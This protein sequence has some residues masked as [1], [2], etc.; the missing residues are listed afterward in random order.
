[1]YGLIIYFFLP[2]FS[3]DYIANVQYLGVKDGLSH[4]DVYCLIKDS[5]GFIWLGTKYG[6]NRYDGHRFQ[7]FTKEKNGLGSN[8]IHHIVEDFDGN[9]WLFTAD[10]WHGKVNMVKASVLNIYRLEVQSLEEKYGA[11][12][13]FQETNIYSCIS[14]K[15]GELFFGTKDGRLVHLKRENIFE[16]QMLK[17]GAEVALILATSQNTVIGS[18]LENNRSTGT[19]EFNGNGKILH[20][21]DTLG[22]DFHPVGLSRDGVYWSI[23]GSQEAN[24]PI[25]FFSALPGNKS[26]VREVSKQ[27]PGDWVFDN[28]LSEIFYRPTDH[29]FWYKSLE[30]FFVF[31][32]EIGLLYDF[33]EEYPEII[34][35]EIHDIYFDKND[36]AWVA[37]GQGFYIIQLSKNPFKRYLFSNP[38]LHSLKDFK[39]CRGILETDNQL[40]VNTYKG[41]F[42]IDLPSGQHQ[43]SYF[44][45]P[46]FNIP[47]FEH[48]FYGPIF[49]KGNDIYQAAHLV[50]KQ[51]SGKDYQAFEWESSARNEKPTIWSIFK[52]SHE[53]VWIGSKSG[54]GYLDTLSRQIQIY[55]QVN[56]FQNIQISTIYDFEERPDSL[57]IASN[58][59]IYI[60]QAEKGIVARYW[61]G[62]K[63][64]YYLPHDDIHH[65]FLD[66]AQ[67]FWLASGGG[68]LIKWNPTRTIQEKGAHIQQFTIAD[69]LSSNTLHAIY[70]DDVQNLWIASEMGIIQ[71][72]R[73]T[74]RTQAYLPENGVSYHEFNRNSHYQ[75]ANGRLY[76][77]S[78]NGVT[79]FFPE[80]I[81]GDTLFNAPL[82]IIQFQ[83]Y[84]GKTESIV[85][86]TTEILESQKIIL[87]P[88][89]RFFNL[90]FAL[91]DYKNTAQV[92]YAYRIRGHSDD[93]QYLN[94]NSLRI[95][96]LP[97][98]NFQ[99]EIRGQGANGMFSSQELSIPIA[100][101]RPLYAK[102]WFIILCLLLFLGGL[103][104]WYKRRTSRLKRQQ[105]ILENMVR[106]RTL[107]IEQ[108]AEE[109][110]HLD[111]L[112]S[113]FFANISHELRT[114]LTLILG[115][116][117]AILK[118]KDIQPKTLVDLKMMQKNGR[119]LIN[120]IGDMLDLTK[121]ESNKMELQEQPV[122][123]YDCLKRILAAFESQAQYLGIVLS[124]QHDFD[125]E[126]KIL[127][128]E[129]K[130][131]KIL[132][133]LLSNALK[134]TPGG[135]K[136]TVHTKDLN[137]II[138]I[139]VTDEGPGIHPA[140]LP[141]I[142]DRY[143]QSK[144]PDAPTQGGTGIGLALAKQLAGIFEGNL[145]VE[146]E[147]GKGSSF[148]FDFPKKETF[149]VIENHPVEEEMV[150]EEEMPLILANHSISSTETTRQQVAILIVEDNP[151]MQNYIQSVLGSQYATKTAKNGAE[152][153]ETLK[154]NPLPQLILSDIMMPVMDGYS[155]LQQLKSTIEWR[156]IPVIMLTARA[157][158]ADKLKALRIGVD[159]YMLKPFETEELHA[160]VKNLLENYSSRMAWQKEL[161]TT[162]AHDHPLLSE[163]DLYWLEQ[164]EK[165]VLREVGNKQYSIGDLAD[166]MAQ[167][168]R[169]L[170]RKLKL[171]TGLSPQKYKLETQL[172]CA[173]TLLHS[174]KYKTVKQVSYAVGFHKTAYFSVLFKKRFGL[175]PSEY[176]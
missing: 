84:D 43:R 107:T 75:A 47:K 30:R 17:E 81:R 152:A 54:L 132:N 53:T 36:L 140:D 51:H 98:G 173:K 155:L 37:T 29:T 138:Q 82:E 61:T 134:F 123:L 18:I 3:Q 156:Q 97:Y 114:P 80:D 126:L 117:S 102:N 73:N 136:V 74:F 86:K 159:D 90:E 89:D 150:F 45:S 172:Q 175:L 49:K 12:I 57:L 120:L 143:Y 34:E 109:L 44:G 167:S 170:E 145:F 8:E 115:P 147:L 108:Q 131:E 96:G 125:P 55:N 168:R 99:L 94:D 24:N 52:D 26:E 63:G 142:F 139:K 176:L 129:L 32:P 15:E 7:L 33:A 40:F 171:L 6:L 144:Q 85:Q 16:S 137:A 104:A 111:E 59:G 130:F 121:L 68:G 116:L 27:I 19:F 65:I 100:V 133:N 119:R 31:Q 153:L 56:A 23:F 60:L 166:E 50:I 64:I 72:D 113:R 76:F 22:E 87:Q 79:A 25:T 38:N 9:L 67:T 103:F 48:P 71:F 70:E 118:R 42:N 46:A 105:S 110:R 69:G 148:I 10:T 78:V 160:R 146:S 154:S 157:A 1:M 39:S 149:G 169:A 151:D 4:R 20:T 58:S 165:I 164:V 95:S 161:E 124:F 141:H 112:K 174:R 28:W 35:K 41:R 77:G 101:L 92:R 135:K 163:E 2:A 14:N 106:E 122:L 91:L 21:Y 128:D 158:Q 13:P 5:R 93:W 11:Q 88:A 83:Q 162:E 66:E 127:L 62:G